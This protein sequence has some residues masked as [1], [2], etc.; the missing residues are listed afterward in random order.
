MNNTLKEN[1]LE[2]VA[3]ICCVEAKAPHGLILDGI[4]PQMI[5]Y[6]GSDSE[7][8]EV[9]KLAADTGT[10]VG[11]IGNGSKIGTF[12]P[13]EKA[14]WIIS[15]STLNQLPHIN[16]E[17]LL[18]TTE[19]GVLLSDIQNDLAKYGLFLPLDGENEETIGGILADGGGASHRLRY[20]LKKDLVLGLSV[21]LSDG[22]IYK[23][24]GQTVKNVAGYDLGK[25]LIGS[26][27]TLG[28]MTEINLRVYPIPPATSLVM[29][30]AGDSGL[31]WKAVK[32]LKR[33]QPTVLEVFDLK[34]A[35]ILFDLRSQETE[36]ERFNTKGALLLV[37][38][39]GPKPTVSQ[40]L[41]ETTQI[42][43]YCNLT[44]ELTLDGQNENQ[45]WQGR[46]AFFSLK[47]RAFFEKRGLKEAIGVKVVVPKDKTMDLALRLESLICNHKLNSAVIHQ[48]ALGISYV[49]VT[50]S[51]AT[52]FLKGLKTLALQLDGSLQV[53]TG[54]IELRKEYGVQLSKYGQEIK[55]L[56]DPMGIFNLGKC[57]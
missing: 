41:L 11:I 31:V 21:A 52:D 26:K 24:G 35:E 39:S 28:V 7:V 2:Q 13:L 10:V 15:T 55:A 34:T 9:L 30:S 25:L 19:P 53:R 22:E 43:K 51:S 29:A 14:E 40:Q 4:K 54:P 27:G 23:F 42:C 56:F 17:D 38:F 46:N 8:A 5:I 20:G 48:G 12:C 3:K 6:P 32:Q 50:G 37:K 16:P 33:L 18:V 57:P 45:V 44:L 49:Y 36:D 47:N 1:V